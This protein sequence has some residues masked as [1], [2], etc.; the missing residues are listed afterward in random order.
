[1]I[2]MR[3]VAVLCA[4][5]AMFV[6]NVA[7]TSA[8]PYPNRPIRIVTA[9]TGG[10]TDLVVRLLAQGLSGSLGQQVIVDNRGGAAG[11][12]AAQTVAKA[13]PDGYSLLAYS[14][15]LWLLTFL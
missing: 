11:A 3:S 13:R 15:N 5:A 12:I 7:G 2:E 14:S 10:A 9:P 6:L 4:V 1:M 8:Q